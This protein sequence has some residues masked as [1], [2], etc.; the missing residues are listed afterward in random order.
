MHH[1]REGHWSVASP[2][3]SAEAF[4]AGTAMLA[5]VLDSGRFDPRIWRLEAGLPD[6]PPDKL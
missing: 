1:V 4:T 2:H 3:E 6:A 5:G